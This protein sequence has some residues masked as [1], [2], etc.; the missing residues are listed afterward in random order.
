MSELN[1][2]PVYKL[3]EPTPSRKSIYTTYI[4]S[5]VWRCVTSPSGAHYWQGKSTGEFICKWCG[6]SRKQGKSN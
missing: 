2:N 5:G 6:E 1:K 4:E 3:D